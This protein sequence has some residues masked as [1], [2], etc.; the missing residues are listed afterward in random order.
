M[1]MVRMC[2]KNLKLYKLV[3]L[4]ELWDYGS[5]IHL[6]YVVVNQI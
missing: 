1:N 2:Q 6:E 5:N 3:V 4:A